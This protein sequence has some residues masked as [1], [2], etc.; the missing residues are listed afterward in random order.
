[1]TIITTILFK[2]GFC[3]AIEKYGT[4]K[5]NSGNSLLYV[6]QNA[7]LKSNITVYLFDNKFVSLYGYGMLIDRNFT[8]SK[9]YIFD[10]GHNGRIIEFNENWDFLEYHSE[11]PTFTSRMV[12]VNETFFIISYHT[13][14]KTDAH[15]KKIKE[16]NFND[17]TSF[18]DICYNS[19]SQTLLVA[20]TI[21]VAGYSTI[22]EFD[23]NLNLV[24]ALGNFSYIQ[25]IQIYKN[26]LYLG[27]IISLLILVNKVIVQKVSVCLYSLISAILFDEYGYMAL[28]CQ[29]IQTIFLYYE[30]GNSTGLNLTTSKLYTNISIYPFDI[31]FDSKGRFILTNDKEI[32]IYF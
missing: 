18:V 24:E 8:T 11:P 29:N 2:Y 12:C 9:N 32:N 1:M 27:G 25:S 16:Y 4:R 28:V 20:S 26:K 5:L 21:F 14:Y 23:L 30:N 15:F 7:T 3:K 13:L 10:Q 31:N 19:T 17:T 6:F 22:Y